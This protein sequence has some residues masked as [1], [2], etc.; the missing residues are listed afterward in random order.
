MLSAFGMCRQYNNSQ[1]SSQWGME[2]Y[3][4]LFQ[5]PPLRSHF[6]PTAARLSQCLY[7]FVYLWVVGASRSD[8]GAS[9]SSLGLPT[10]RSRLPPRRSVSSS[11]LHPLFRCITDELKLMA[12]LQTARQNERLLFFCISGSPFLGGTSS[13]PQFHNHLGAWRGLEPLRAVP[14]GTPFA[15]CAAAPCTQEVERDRL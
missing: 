2:L 12:V 10:L 4:I 9:S 15:S 1:Q 13:S 14:C 8:A 6:Q 7:K 3:S 11:V 5:C